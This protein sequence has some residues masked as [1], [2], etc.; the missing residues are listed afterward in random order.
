MFC[1]CPYDSD[2][3]DEEIKEKAA[4]E[5]EEHNHMIDTIKNAGD[6]IKNVRVISQI[7]DLTNTIDNW[8]TEI[9]NNS[10]KNGVTNEDRKMLVDAMDILKGATRDL[11]KLNCNDREDRLARTKKAA[12]M[13]EEVLNRTRRGRKGSGAESTTDDSD[14]D[15]ISSNKSSDVG[16]GKR[17]EQNHREVTISENWWD[18]Y[19][20][21]IVERN[22]IVPKRICVLL[23]SEMKKKDFNIF[24]PFYAIDQSGDLARYAYISPFGIEEATRRASRFL[25]FYRNL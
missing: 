22:E 16:L 23:L 2:E 19:E 1:C 18:A 8:A 21:S 11:E 24:H 20:E 7:S 9:K 5:K 3:S 10:V 12:S 4:K 15:L 17:K 14:S 13:F 6:T 25:N